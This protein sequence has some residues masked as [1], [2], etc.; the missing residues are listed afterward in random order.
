VKVV[1]CAAEIPHASAFAKKFGR[2]YTG[3]QKNQ[4]AKPG[5]KK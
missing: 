5:M 4:M 1:I 3:I 2:H